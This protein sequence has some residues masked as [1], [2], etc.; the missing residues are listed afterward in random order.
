MTEIARFAE[1]GLFAPSEPFFGETQTSQKGR[2]KETKWK[3][4]EAIFAG[5]EVIGCHKNLSESI[6]INRNQSE[7]IRTNQNQSD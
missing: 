5:F 3:I 4:W 2:K 6:R 7:L 1:T